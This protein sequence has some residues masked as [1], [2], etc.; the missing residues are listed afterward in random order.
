MLTIGVKR[1]SLAMLVAVTMLI[2]LTSG[3]MTVQAQDGVTLT[4]GL[5]ASPQDTLLTEALGAIVQAGFDSKAFDLE[6]AVFDPQGRAMIMPIKDLQTRLQEKEPPTLIGVLY[7]RESLSITD[8]Q[9]LFQIDLKRFKVVAKV[10]QVRLGLYP[11]ELMVVENGY[12]HKSPNDFSG[13]RL[14][15]SETLCWGI[16]IGEFIQFSYQVCRTKDIDGGSNGGGSN[17]GTGQEGGFQGEDPLC[18]LPVGCWV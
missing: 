13:P 15:D 18:P 5:G 6:K 2:A 1:G 3:T 11:I 7:V 10:N 8:L 16:S 12:S 4:P 9:E 14:T 17:D